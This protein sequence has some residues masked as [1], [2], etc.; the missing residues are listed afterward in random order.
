M[1]IT[2]ILL[3]LSQ[4]PGVYPPLFFPWPLFVHVGHTPVMTWV[5]C[6]T[7]I[8][9]LSVGRSILRIYKPENQ[10]WTIL[11]NPELHS[12]ATFFKLILFKKNIHTLSVHLHFLHRHGTLAWDGN[13]SSIQYGCNSKAERS[14]SLSEYQKFNS[15]CSSFTVQL[16][17]QPTSHIQYKFLF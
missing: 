9:S 8:T 14:T 17:Q 15:P 1:Y 10:Y 4:P 13:L 12:I 11:Q 3:L 2:L 7:F 5:T 6:H 16:V